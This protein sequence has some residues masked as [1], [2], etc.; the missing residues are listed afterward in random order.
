[1]GLRFITHK[2]HIKNEQYSAGARDGKIRT[3][4]KL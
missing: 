1:M 3:L 2:I 4:E